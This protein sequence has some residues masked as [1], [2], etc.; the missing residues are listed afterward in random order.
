MTML[1]V[2]GPTSVSCY[3]ISAAAVF[4]SPVALRQR[5]PLG[6]SIGQGALEGD[7]HDHAG[8]LV[9]HACQLL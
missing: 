5:Q 3:S 4:S 2:L 7:S 6:A 1:A 9:A 8:S